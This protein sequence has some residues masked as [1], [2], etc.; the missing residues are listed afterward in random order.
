MATSG[1]STILVGSPC[2]FFGR[3][4]RIGPGTYSS[5]SAGREAFATSYA[6]LLSSREAES[7]FGSKASR[8]AAME[9]DGSVEVDPIPVCSS[10]GF[11]AAFEMSGRSRIC[12]TSCALKLTRCRFLVF[13][14]LVASGRAAI[15][16]SLSR[17][18]LRLRFHRIRNRSLWYT[19]AML[20]RATACS[21]FSRPCVWN[22]LSGQ[23]P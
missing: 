1:E 11:H 9:P 3:P 16:R 12:T 10:I 2:S 4:P 17:H 7:N 15:T 21:R 8:S 20:L 5:R 14:Q 19:V 23:K 6:R 18:S 13:R 22:R